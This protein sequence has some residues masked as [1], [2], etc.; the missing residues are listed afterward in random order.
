M[1]AVIIPTRNRPKLLINLLN[2]ITCTLTSKDTIIIVDS[3]DSQSRPELPAFNVPIL[4]SVTDIKSAAVQRNI[5]LD[6]IGESK[7]V[8]FLDDDVIP[9]R[10]YFEKIVEDLMKEG[11]VG[12]SGRAIS[13]TK[14]I[15]G[16]PVGINGLFHRLFLLDSSH[17]GKLLPSGVNIPLRSNSNLSVEVD[18]LIGCS[19]WNAEKIQETRFE[20]DFT[21]QSLAEDVIFSV[22]MKR[23]GKLIVNPNIELFHFE[24]EIGRPNAEEFWYMWIKNRWRLI[25]VMRLGNKGSIAF[26]W[27][28][29]GQMLISIYLPIKKRTFEFEP[30]KGLCRG[31]YNIFK[32]ANEN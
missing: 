13:A 9:P 18:W 12:V 25:K 17:D 16:M 5:G 10:D 6:R 14:A 30:L 29:L 19:A 27:A 4:Y 23:K 22:K 15:R 11:V 1:K 21:G 26:W 32:E 24:S 20:S 2:E 8:F 3:S 28:N 7:Y 31:A